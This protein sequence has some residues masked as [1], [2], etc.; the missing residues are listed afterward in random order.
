MKADKIELISTQM[1]GKV[2]F[3]LA[4]FSVALTACRQDASPVTNQNNQPAVSATVVPNISVDN[5][6]NLANVGSSAESNSNKTIKPTPTASATPRASVSPTA[7]PKISGNAKFKNYNG[8]GV[9]KKI[10]AENGLIVIDH[11]DIGDYMIA[12]EMPFPV[13]NKKILDGLKVGDR[14]TFVLET[15]VGVERIIKIEKR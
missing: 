7:S 13:V 9:V 14:V 8:R 4:L 11:E 12:M 3:G 1:K 2:L 10:D 15:G 5:N 6:G